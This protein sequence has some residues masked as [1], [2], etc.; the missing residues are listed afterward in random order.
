MAT[1][2]VV[3]VKGRAYPRPG[4]RGEFIGLKRAPK[5]APEA[6]IVHRVPDGH[7]YVSAGVVEVPDVRDMRMAV[8]RGDLAPAPEVPAPKRAPKEG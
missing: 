4:T 8:L 1:I 2:R 5:D 6:D 7:A 3:A